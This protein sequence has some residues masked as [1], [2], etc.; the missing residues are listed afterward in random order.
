MLSLLP[1]GDAGSLPGVGAPFQK[2]IQSII[3]LYPPPQAI[4]MQ[5]TRM[6]SHVSVIFMRVSLIGLSPR[7]TSTVW[8][9]F[10]RLTEDRSNKYRVFNFV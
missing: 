3:G 10:D 5:M 4:L 9:Y 1:L 8:A 2:R 7:R 6:Q